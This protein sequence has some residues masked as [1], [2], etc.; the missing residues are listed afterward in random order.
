MKISAYQVTT[1]LDFR[2]VI[3]KLN[4]CADESGVG[5]VAGVV[6]VELLNTPRFGVVSKCNAGAELP[7]C[8]TSD[9]DLAL[10]TNVTV[11]PPLLNGFVVATTRTAFGLPINGDDSSRSSPVTRTSTDL[12]SF[13]S[14]FALPNQLHRHGGGIF[15][16]ADLILSIGLS[17]NGCFSS[18]AQNRPF[19]CSV[20]FCWFLELFVM[21]ISSAS[22]VPLA[23]PND[24]SKSS[25]SKLS[26]SM[27]GMLLQRF[28]TFVSDLFDALRVNV[29]VRT[30]TWDLR[31]RL[32]LRR[33]GDIGLNSEKII[34]K[35]T[36][37]LHFHG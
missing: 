5:E 12:I 28:R 7:I 9:G 6:V 4:L 25:E 26:C 16:S 13:G 31:R 15:G 19:D 27:R 21:C 10:L 1:E 22:S 32:S 24:D 34:K 33:A 18:C 29:D 17:F 14:G 8:I 37:K 36:W 30:I 23:W 11:V 35:N 3:V 2:G 20:E